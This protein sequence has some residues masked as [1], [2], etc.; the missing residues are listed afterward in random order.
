MAYIVF[1]HGI[2]SN[3]TILVALICANYIWAVCYTNFRGH[4]WA[5]WYLDI[6]I[7]ESM[8]RHSCHIGV[9]VNRPQ[10]VKRYHMCY[11]CS[12]IKCS[13]HV[14]RHLSIHAN[15]EP[16]YIHSSSLRSWCLHLVHYYIDR[17]NT[18]TFLLWSWNQGQYPT[19]THIIHTHNTS[20]IHGSFFHK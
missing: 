7:S 1:L 17:L 2:I 9:C 15:H 8:F 13:Y 3:L 5:P 11:V 4:T 12:Y 10:Q 19:N 18:I 16:C 6:N 20:Y 14:K